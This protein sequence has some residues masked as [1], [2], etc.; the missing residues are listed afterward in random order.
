M[1][2]APGVFNRLWGA[3]TPFSKIPLYPGQDN[4]WR[5]NLETMEVPM[6]EAVLVIRGKVERNGVLEEAE[7]MVGNLAT[8][9]P[10]NGIVLIHTA[11]HGELTGYGALTQRFRLH[12]E[13]RLLV[14]C[15]LEPDKNG[16]AYT[17]RLRD[18]RS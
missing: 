2:L 4:D 14:D 7:I 17:I 9:G 12:D 5:H 6:E 16:H 15:A 18:V 10:D 11:E 3:M 8:T 1:N 13:Y